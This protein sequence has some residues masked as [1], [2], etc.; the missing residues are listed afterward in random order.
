MKTRRA[1]QNLLRRFHQSQMK[2][3][4]QLPLAAQPRPRAASAS[5]SCNHKSFSVKPADLLLLDPLWV[6]G[7]RPGPSDSECISCVCRRKKW[8]SVQTRH[9]TCSTVWTTLTKKRSSQ[10]PVF[11]PCPSLHISG[12]G[13]H[14]PPP[15][16]W[17]LET[18]RNRRL[19]KAVMMAVTGTVTS[20][21]ALC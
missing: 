9:G 14:S 7:G 2:R 15:Q 4:L 17:D 16:Q 18:E 12:K 19:T 8:M 11:C 13:A 5:Q 20:R 1:T 3:K 21:Q 6:L 10:K